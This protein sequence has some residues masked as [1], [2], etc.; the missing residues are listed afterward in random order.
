MKIL[1]VVGHYIPHIGGVEILFQQFVKG[2]IA[3][4]HEVRVVTSSSGGIVG[5]K[6]LDGAEVYGY[7]WKIFCGHP[8]A[9]VRDIEEH[10]KWA[11]IVHTT[12]FTVAPPTLKACKKLHKPCLITIHEVLGDKWF[13]VEPNKI[14][15]FGFKMFEQYVCCKPYDYIH[16]DSDS[17]MN[18]YFK[19]YHKRD[20]VRRIYLCVDDNVPRLKQE[21]SVKLKDVFDI[22]EEAKTF[23]YFGRPGQSKGIFVLLDAIEILKREHENELKNIKFCFLISNDPKKQRDIFE[24]MVS[25][26]GLSDIVKTHDSVKR[27][28]LFKIVSDSD[29]VIVPSITEGFGF[30]AAETCALHKNII[31]SNGGSLP[32]VVSGNIMGFENRNSKDLAD[33]ILKVIQ[34]G[35]SE[36]EFTEYK[37]FTSDVMID[38]LLEY[39]N[40][41]MV[42]SKIT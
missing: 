34:N 24:K 37:T 5:K 41:L 31:Y 39:Y 7:D 25:K 22:P 17:T 23:L 40:L 28:D 26:K 16:F 20:R 15:A 35:N 38:S 3:H 33:K 32:E 29:C 36:F 21:S 8:I 2:M 14:K 11:D 27:V 12:T 4:G 19:Y 42:N 6:E 10:A 1:Y 13:W 9:K 30:C 18:D